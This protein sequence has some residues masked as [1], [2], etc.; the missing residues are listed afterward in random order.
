MGKI[1]LTFTDGNKIEVNKR[2]KGSEILD[3]LPETV[4]SN[5][6]VSKS[7]DSEDKDKIVAIKV[8]N[9][10]ISLCRPIR[11]SSKV[12]PVFLR[13][14]QGAAIYRRSL[15]F[16]L[17]AA[18]HKLFPDAHLLVGHSLGYGY[19]YT[20]ESGGNLTAEQIKNLESE[21]KKIV[22]SDIPIETQH[23][24]YG[25]AES[26]LENLK[27]TESKKQLEVVSRREVLVNKFAGDRNFLDLYFGPLVSSTGILKVFE[28]KP[29][30]DGFLLRFPKH[31]GL[32]VSQNSGTIRKFSRF[33]RTIKNGEKWSESLRP[34]R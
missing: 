14:K 31:T 13:S 27:L 4:A 15:C 30:G 16:I 3:K 29:Y 26:A 23:I 19:Y 8:D 17:A 34:L 20:L 24:S 5:S 18:S 10:I 22:D 1:T 9:E 12:E 33:I 11:V 6:C 7:C 32:S 28:L 21:M 2:V 25:E